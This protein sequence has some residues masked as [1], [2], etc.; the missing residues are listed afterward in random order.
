MPI[1]PFRRGPEQQDHGSA[2][3][4]CATRGMKVQEVQEHEHFQTCRRLFGVSIGQSESGLFLVVSSVLRGLASEAVGLSRRPS[5][6]AGRA[7]APLYA[8]DCRAVAAVGSAD[9]AVS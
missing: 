3:G 5:R 2:P 6:G 8:T 4:T 9:C 1:F 7:G